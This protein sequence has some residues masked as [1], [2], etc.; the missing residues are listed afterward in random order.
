MAKA[1]VFSRGVFGVASK[2]LVLA[3]FCAMSA[4]SWSGGQAELDAFSKTRQFAEGQFEQTVMAPNGKV[5]QSGTGRFA[6]SRPGKFLWEIEKPYPQ[7]IVAD[8]KSVVTFDKDLAQA[9]TRPLGQ[10][11]DSS[12]AAL[13][14][15]SQSLDKLF[16]IQ[17]KGNQ[18]GKQWLA[19]KPRN[20]ETLFETI[21]IGMQD[22]LPVELEIK[23]AMGQVTKLKLKNWRFDR[24]RPDDYFK[25]ELPAGV[26]L[27]QA[28]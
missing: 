16:D 4:L 13:L 25:F 14:F 28:N 11:I 27:I 23:D 15:G 2:G 5:K 10:S 8:G 9:S 18:N 6:F 19:A 12:P 26:D 7:L 20:S 1:G 22:G 3:A 21:L 17:D 24:K